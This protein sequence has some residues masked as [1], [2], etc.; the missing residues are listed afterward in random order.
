[1][2]WR[3]RGAR[4]IFTEAPRSRRLRSSRAARTFIISYFSYLHLIWSCAPYFQLARFPPFHFVPRL[5]CRPRDCTVDLIARRTLGAHTMA[6]TV[7]E[8]NGAVQVVV[9][10]PD[11]DGKDSVS[12]RASSNLAA[13]EVHQTLRAWCHHWPTRPCQALAQLTT[14]Q[15]PSQGKSGH[16]CIHVRGR[17]TCSLQQCC[18]AWSILAIPSRAS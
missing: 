7:G 13:S 12:L 2:F 17:H 15:L 18:A 16:V 3:S 14:R 4:S 10:G 5:G 6:V 9:I 8:P 1:M 11:G